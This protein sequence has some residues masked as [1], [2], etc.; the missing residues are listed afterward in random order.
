MCQLQTPIIKIIFR[1]RITKELTDFETD[2]TDH[3]EKVFEQKLLN[4]F[5]GEDDKRNLK[6]TLKAF[7]ICITAIAGILISLA[8][9]ILLINDA[10]SKNQVNNKENATLNISGADYCH[11]DLIDTYPKQD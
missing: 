7:L 6:N 10:R 4:Y 8:G 2:F 9:G 11:N 5:K 1:D 3:S